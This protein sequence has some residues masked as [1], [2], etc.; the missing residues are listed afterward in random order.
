M[1]IAS[2]EAAFFLHP[3]KGKQI[4]S[5]Q[6]LEILDKLIRV[7]INDEDSNVREKVFSSVVKNFK[8]H[9]E[10]IHL[11]SNMSLLSSLFKAL[12]DRN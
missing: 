10:F 1:K 3:K 7:G 8:R 4:A 12:E 2:V 5:N 6:I 9:E 11:F